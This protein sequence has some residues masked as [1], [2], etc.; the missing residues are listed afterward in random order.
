M[1]LECGSP[2]A[3]A[4]AIV[5]MPEQMVRHYDQAVDKR[6][7]AVDAMKWLEAAWTGVRTLGRA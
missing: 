7:L 5:M 2:E 3:E 6:R 4:S 1:L